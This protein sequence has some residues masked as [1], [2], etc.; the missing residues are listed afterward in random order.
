[1]QD[2]RSVRIQQ[3]RGCEIISRDYHGI[4]CLVTNGKLI[5]VQQEDGDA[6]MQIQLIVEGTS[7][8]GTENEEGKREGGG[9]RRKDLNPAMDDL[10]TFARET[11]EVAGRRRHAI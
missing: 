3:R 10:A 9:T 7:I 6:N 1:M 8:E 11:L 5:R 4:V 2:S